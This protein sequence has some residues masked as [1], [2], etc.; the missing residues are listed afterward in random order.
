MALPNCPDQYLNEPEDY[1]SDEELDEMSEAL[2]EN[3]EMFHDK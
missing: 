3:Y 1:L 2:I